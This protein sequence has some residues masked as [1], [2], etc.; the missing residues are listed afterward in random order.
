MND[1]TF[2]LAMAYGGR[3]KSYRWQE[4]VPYPANWQVGTNN[5]RI[6]EDICVWANALLP[7]SKDDKNFFCPATPIR[8]LDGI[9][10]RIQRPLPAAMTYVYNGLLHQLPRSLAE[11]QEETGFFWEGMGRIT[12][13]GYFFSSPT[14]VC[15]PQTECRFDRGT[16]PA[17]LR[18]LFTMNIHKNGFCFITIAGS[19]RME[20][21]SKSRVFSEATTDGVVQKWRSSGGFPI[22]FR[23][24]G[25]GGSGESAA[26]LPW[27]VSHS[28]Q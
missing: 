14:L 2:P 5:Q 23:P 19:A 4:P 27:V 6:S 12:I 8:H 22:P 13:N 21:L 3:E 11:N 10:Y 28:A 7:L 16:R 1:D 24:N 9:D 17:F 26:F 25:T 15:T 18:P 20:K